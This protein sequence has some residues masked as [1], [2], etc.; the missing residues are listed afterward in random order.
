MVLIFLI[1]VIVLC[2]YSINKLYKQV[3]TLR[4][5]YIDMSDAYINKITELKEYADCIDNTEADFNV[6]VLINAVGTAEKD[7]DLTLDKH[8]KDMEKAKLPKFR[9]GEKADY[10]LYG[11]HRRP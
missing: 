1:I 2:V 7:W 8:M 4:Y 9:N 10:L 3:E 11:R 6:D 5:C